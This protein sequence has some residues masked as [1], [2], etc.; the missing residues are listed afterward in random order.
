MGLFIGNIDRTLL[1]N[2]ILQDKLNIS[3]AKVYGVR[4]DGSNPFGQRLYDA[5]DLHFQ[6]STTTFTGED[7]FISISEPS[8]VPEPYRNCTGIV[9]DSPY[10]RGKR[11]ITK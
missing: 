8:S 11:R 4:F 3:S 5:Y 6:P 2:Q 9:P 7:D 1:P 10:H